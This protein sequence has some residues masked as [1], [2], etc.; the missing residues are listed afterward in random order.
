MMALFCN[1]IC[2][3][4]N[5]KEKIYVF[6]CTLVQS[7]Q[8][9]KFLVSPPWLKSITT[10][11]T[12]LAIQVIPKEEILI[13]HVYLEGALFKIEATSIDKKNSLREARVSQILF[14]GKLFCCQIQLL[15]WEL[16]DRKSWVKI[17]DIMLDK[18][19]IHL[20]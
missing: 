1:T 12:R 15:P 19:C 6:D 5:H 7:Q 11:R 10:K 20:I 13:T 2:I 9:S 3:V 17:R 14:L 8:T 16:I 4:L 18:K